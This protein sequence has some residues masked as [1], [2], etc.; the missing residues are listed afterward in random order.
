[1]GCDL[2]IKT[3]DAFARKQRRCMDKLDDVGLFSGFAQLSVVLVATPEDGHDFVEG[4]RYRLA[5]RKGS[6]VVADGVAVVGVVE[7][8][9]R[10]VADQLR[11]PRPSASACV[12]TRYKLTNK[13]DLQLME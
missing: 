12:V 3:K 4:K 10:S 2:I 5:M 7:D 9:P 6:L 1:M 13:A 11:G 8:P